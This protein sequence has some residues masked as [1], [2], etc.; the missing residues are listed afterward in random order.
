M[1]RM[2]ALLLASL[3][4]LAQAH[5]G[6]TAYLQATATGAEVQ[7]RADYALRDLD[8][9]LGVDANDDGQL[10]WSELQAAE[11]ALLAYLA[12]RLSVRGDGQPCPLA[13]DGA[14]Q[15]AEHADGPYAVFR[16]SGQCASAPREWQLSDTAL[17]EFDANH[18]ALARWQRGDDGSAGVLRPDATVLTLG[19]TRTAFSTF[20]AYL[21]EGLAHVWSGWDHMLFIAGLFLPAA[22]LRRAGRWQPV[23]RLGPA[24]ADAVKLVTAFTIAH[25]ITL[26]LTALGVVALPTRLVESLVALSVVFAGFNNLLPLAGRR[27]MFLLA[28]VFGLIHGTAIA[29]ALLELGLP[30]SGRLLALL[31]FNLGVEAAQL[32]LVSLLVPLAFALRNWRGY[33]SV[34]LWPGSALVVLAGLIW[35]VDRAFEMEWA[36]PI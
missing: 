24:L 20:T 32:L 8:D 13:T 36:L 12:P 23:P 5:S 19:A 35:F 28:W 31:G 26:C 7:L 33:V 25:A 30:P 6:S 27:L 34:V 15:V 9:A 2:A 17:F 16:F 22:L 10:T 1:K 29:G 14:V 11:P 18:R 3:A 4:G 21:H